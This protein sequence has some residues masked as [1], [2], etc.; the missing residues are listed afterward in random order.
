MLPVEQAGL[1]YC[2]SSLLLFVFVIAELG[3]VELTNIF[4]IPA[5]FP[6]L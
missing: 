2:A 1:L 6:P 4:S 3:I 5:P